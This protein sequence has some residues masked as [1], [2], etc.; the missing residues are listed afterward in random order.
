MIG[1]NK[2]SEKVKKRLYRKPNGI[3][4]TILLV[5]VG[6]AVVL[7]LPRDGNQPSVSA[8]KK[9][10]KVTRI[11]PSAPHKPK[12][13][14]QARTLTKVMNE[15]EGMV[16]SSLGVWQPA[17]RPWRADRRKVHAV[18]TNGA[19]RV[20]QPLPYNN[21]TEQLLLQ[22]FGREVGL[23]PFPLLKLPKKDMDNLVGILM[24]DNPISDKDS[25]LIAISKEIITEAKAEMRKYIKDGGNPTEF[26]EYYHGLLRRAYDKRQIAK[27]EILRIAREEKDLELARLLQKEVNDKLIEEGIKPLKLDLPD[28]YE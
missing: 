7:L 25:E 14:Q 6:I 3:F 8:E 15:H 26:F 16:K 21:A 24:S 19:N 18:H 27:K 1:S 23:S 4:L 28:D 22:T 17:D 11:K 2:K 13:E 9:A 12:Q 5:A 10:N 20:R